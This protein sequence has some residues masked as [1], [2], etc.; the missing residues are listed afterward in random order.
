[1]LAFVQEAGGGAGTAR[2]EAVVVEGLHFAA[3]KDV[4][5]VVRVDGKDNAWTKILGLE[6]GG[7]W[8]YD[9]NFVV[10]VVTGFQGFSLTHHTLPFRLAGPSLPRGQ[11]RR[12][13]E[14]YL[15]GDVQGG[16][17]VVE[18]AEYRLFSEYQRKGREP[19]A[20]IDATADNHEGRGQEL[21]PVVWFPQGE[22]GAESNE[23]AVE[24]FDSSIG[25]RMVGGGDNPVDA[26]AETR[27]AALFP[28]EFSAAVSDDDLRTSKLP[29]DLGA[30]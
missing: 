4:I 6:L 1:M 24:A 3:N 17:F 19:G 18:G 27:G 29:Y 20:S 16:R 13:L 10:D 11:S 7:V 23:G 28:C 2:A 30:G 5:G 12:R 21:V 25:L 26:V 14:R 15:R 8:V 22:L 9:P